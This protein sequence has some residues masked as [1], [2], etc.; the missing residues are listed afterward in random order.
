VGFGSIA[1]LP[2]GAKETGPLGPFGYLE[3]FSQSTITTWKKSESRT[4]EGAL[5][6]EFT[7]VERKGSDLLLPGA[8]PTFKGVRADGL[9]PK[10]DFLS[11]ISRCSSGR[12]AFRTK[13]SAPTR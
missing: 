3:T 10:L 7:P 4:A 13:S 2:G 5:R 8:S 12:R 1:A 6:T 9:A 11:L